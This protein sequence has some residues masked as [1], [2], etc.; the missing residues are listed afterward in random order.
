[1]SNTGALVYVVDDVTCARDGVADLIR[2][3]GLMARTFASG[4]EFLTASRREQASC[5]VLDVNLPGV[6]GLEVQ[7]ELAKSDVHVPIIFLTGCGDIPMT[8]RAVKSGAV[9][10]LTKPFDEE[11]LL[12]AIRQCITSCDEERSLELNLPTLVWLRQVRAR[13]AARLSP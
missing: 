8:V 13:D 10:V 6:S 11:V 2:S 12:N 5:L 4:E 1:M 9:N 7:Q 3:A